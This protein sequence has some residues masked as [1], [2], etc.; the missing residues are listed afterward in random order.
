MSNEIPI[1]K[2]INIKQFETKQSKYK[3][4][5]SLPT[6]SILLGPSGAGK[7]VLFIQFNFR[8]V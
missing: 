8:C 3:M 6:R 7:G 2:P 4:V 1:I 5:G